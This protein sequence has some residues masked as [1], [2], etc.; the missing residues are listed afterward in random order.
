MLVWRLPSR[1][2]CCKIFFDSFSGW[3][4]PADQPVSGVSFRMN[5]SINEPGKKDKP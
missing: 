3:S 2:F 5:E 4:A 1:P